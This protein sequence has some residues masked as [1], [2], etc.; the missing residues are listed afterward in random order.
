MAAN[1]ITTSRPILALLLAVCA[2][3]AAASARGAEPSIIGG[4]MPLEYWVGQQDNSI[5]LV[6]QVERST[7]P[8]EAPSQPFE[9]PAQPFEAPTTTT[10][11]EEGNSFRASP[12]LRALLQAEPQPT[13]DTVAR[14]EVATTAP[15]D[16]GSMLQNS[17]NVQT[18]GAQ[19]RSQ[20]AFDPHVR[21][22]RFGEIYSQGQGEYFLP[23]RL[24]LDSMLSKIDPYLMQNV[25]VIP[26]PYGL[27][28]GP[29]FAFID[30]A[31]VDT[32]RSNCCGIEWKNRFNTLYRGN[33]SQIL[34][35][36]TVMGGAQ[37]YGFITNY[38][39]RSGA[40]YTAGN[41]QKI[42][43]SYHTQNVLLQM[44]FDTPNGRTEFRY[45]RLDLWNTEYAL[46]FFDVNSMRTDSF[47]L[48]YAGNDPTVDA[49]NNAQ[50]WY[51]NTG[52]N[53]DDLR[54]SKT[55]LRTRIA[56]GLNNDFNTQG[57][58]AGSFQ[59]F[60]NGNL[61]NTGAR[62]V[63]TYGDEQSDYARV[64]AD[65]RYITQDT[66]ERFHIQ[67][68]PQNFLRPDEE[69]FRTNMPH[70]ALTDPGVF[71]EWGTPWLSF[72]KTAIGG[73]VDWVNTHPRT[74]EFDNT[75]GVP[76][77]SD[78]NFNQNDVLLASYLTGELE[79]TQTWTIR[80][81]VGYAERVPDL[82]NR[83]SDGVF[84]GI[85]Q[86][87]FNKVV[88]FPGLKKERATQMDVS[89]LADYGYMTGR[90]SAF[91][92]WIND[93]NTYTTFGV[94]PPTGANILLASNTA[95]A[96]LGGFELY[97]D[98]RATDVI[99]YFATMQYIRGTAQIINRPLT[100]IYPLQS[101]L[102]VRFT[103]PMPQNDWG[104][105]LGLRMVAQQNQ[106]GF[107]RD[108]V[109]GPPTSVAVETATAGF[110]TTY[111]RGYYNLSQQIHLV[112]GI[113]NMFNR[114]YIEHLDLRL[115]GPAQSPGGVTAALA[116]G[117]TAYAGLEWFM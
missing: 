83:Y 88:G 95:L 90:A 92:S 21:G 66:N 18:L 103:D 60:S 61:V 37:N 67:D 19:R 108:N 97:G 107:L 17:D 8:F 82:V 59:G 34:M 2:V 70:S 100:Q 73:R 56:N 109:G 28:Y 96:T 11:A 84:L 86:N 74:S 50:V 12:A 36:D 64:G 102:G 91:Y 4:P 77:I 22:Y 106:V 51:N 112:G 35:Q 116:P 71:A 32:P 45:N 68:L 1:R 10:G 25:T 38:S 40:D 58:N 20:V 47:N 57:F 85:L 3:F 111:L 43:Y 80:G 63:R 110:Y 48:N 44:G 30:V 89:A 27:R 42:P 9:T 79:L 14:G 105:E 104:L 13:A 53:G 65:V 26:G 31:L 117:F 81:G 29:G 93:Y 23:V 76:G 98:Y 75:P 7:Q 41:G 87:G 16:L 49:Q 69:N 94:D 33:G 99:T 55:E 78:V 15:T 62:A 72:F 52:F 39:L 115:R 113:D 6:S 5:R 46:Q 101:R 54:A 24:D 114:A